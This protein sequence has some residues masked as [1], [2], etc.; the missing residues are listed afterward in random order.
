MDIRSTV[1]VGGRDGQRQY[2]PR[3]G[4]EARKGLAARDRERK[5]TVSS[6]W[7]ETYAVPMLRLR[8]EWLRGAGFESGSRVVVRAT[9]GRLVFSLL[10]EKR[11]ED[12]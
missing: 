2:P 7:N 12:G 11:T 8:G 5:L 10:T 4:R 1:S 9:R 6:F 3:E